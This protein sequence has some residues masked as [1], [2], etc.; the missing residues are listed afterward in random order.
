MIPSRYASYL[1]FLWVA[2]L[3]ALLAVLAF[4]Q[5]RWTGEA[6][7]A[8]QERMRRGLRESLSYLEKDFDREI[9]SILLSYWR[10]VAV[11]EHRRPS[12][13]RQPR[14]VSEPAELPAPRLDSLAEIAQRLAESY[15]RWRAVTEDPRLIADLL[16]ADGLGGGA[17]RLL[18][19]DPGAGALTPIDWPPEL[20]RLR[21]MSD[22]Y[23][24]GVH[25]TVPHA[26]ER[27]REI[28]LYPYVADE[29]PALVIPLAFESARRQPGDSEAPVERAPIR[30][31]SVLIIRFDRAYLF[32]QLVPALARRYLP[33]DGEN[34]YDYALIGRNTESVL[35]ASS[36][37][38][39]DK[40]LSAPD[41]FVDLMRLQSEH[42]EEGTPDGIE[43]GPVDQTGGGR[44][45][46]HMQ[47]EPAAVPR[48]SGGVPG[49]DRM[50]QRRPPG[51]APELARRRPSQ[52]VA[53]ATEAWRRD[54]ERSKQLQQFAEI[55][56]SQGWRFAVKHRAGSLDRIVAV[57]RVRNL[58]VS[59]SI[60]LVLATSL[61]LLSISVRRAQRLARQQM[62]F[63]ASVSHE[64]RTPIAVICSNAENLA[65]GLIRKDDQVR[66]YGG[67]ILREGR[68]LGALVEQTLEYA[69]ITSGQ[70]RVD[71]RPISLGQLVSRTVD[72]FRA[73]LDQS[74]VR[75][76]Q[77][78]S[79]SVLTIRGDAASLACALENLLNNA[80]K[81][82][83]A[84]RT[85]RVTV[86]DSN[87]AK[88]V[89]LSV[90]DQGMGI[91]RAEL[92]RVF[93]PFFR[94]SNAVRAQIRGAGVGLSLVK[95]IV[96]AHHGKIQVSSKTGEGTVFTIAFPATEQE[97]AE[98]ADPDGDP[99]DR[100]Y[101]DEGIASPAPEDPHE[102]S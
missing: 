2:G 33:S 31:N 63:I 6:S 43:S 88:S 71:L 74:A 60:L 15:Q 78:I 44:G 47:A 16:V 35:C 79:P 73:R 21:A 72:A 50:A 95:K 38:A 34:A 89:E 1:R 56:A 18:R 80:V 92:A 98:Q 93:E 22:S 28:L 90:A 53:S 57:T 87:D 17:G 20:F 96:E 37:A 91:E 30:A 51:S 81:Y 14:E 100:P 102:R 62:E 7:L 76:E 55:L 61:V 5:Y 42:S 19:F 39:R 26:V 48:P 41:A 84:G 25:G 49:G 94:G 59:L 45:V 77:D 67:F 52:I 54:L 58:I 8:E 4:L 68:R 23:D 101:E 69:G 64:L 27:S 70:R 11:E 10:P 13:R 32:E 12:P 99:L 40:I 66:R 83:P 86:K 97:Q 65:D 36:G 75:F 46:S 24:T 29:M 85:I 9:T 82:S 3:L